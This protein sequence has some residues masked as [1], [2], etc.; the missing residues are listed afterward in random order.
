MPHLEHVLDDALK[1]VHCRHTPVHHQEFTAREGSTSLLKQPS[2]FI[3]QPC[4]PSDVINLGLALPSNPPS[5][6][7]VCNE[8]DLEF[9]VYDC[10]ES[11]LELKDSRHECNLEMGAA[12]QLQPQV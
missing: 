12:V 4:L 8:S 7:Y 3:I 6:I 10:N 5:L 2:R 1:R 11:D 9:R